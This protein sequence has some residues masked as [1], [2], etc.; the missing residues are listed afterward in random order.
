M[1]RLTSLAILI[2]FIILYKNNCPAAIFQPVKAAQ[3]MVVTADPYATQVGIEVLKKGGNAVDAAVAVAFTLAVTYPSAGNIGGGGFMMIRDS[4]HRIFALDFRERAPLAATRDMFL[5]QNG[6]VIEKLSILG[7]LAAGTPGTVHGLWQA[8][9][10]FGRLK[11][12]ALLKAAIDLAENGFIIDDYNAAALQDACADFN[13][14]L[15]AKKIFTKNGQ[16]FIAG[17]RLRQKDLAATLKRIATKGLDGFYDGLTADLI[18]KE[19]RANSGLLTKKDLQSYRS[20]WREPIAIDYRGSRIFSMP[21]PSSGGIVL[22]EI[23]NCLESFDLKTIGH[24]SANAIHLWVEIE[25]QA[26][27]DR[28]QWLGDSDFISVPVARLISR[29]YAKSLLP[30]L[31]CFV[32]GNSEAISSKN[33]AAHEAEQTTHFSIVDA[34]NN[35]VAVTYTL[36]GGYG[37]RAVIEGTGILLNNEMDDFSIKAGHPNMYG[38]IG[39]LANAIEPGKRML[40]SMTPTILTRNDSLLMVIGSPGGSTIITTVAQVISNVIDQQMNIRQA[41]EA[42]RFHHQWLPDVVDLESGGFSLDTIHSLESKGFCLRW[43]DNIGMAEG[44]LI[45][46]KQQQITGWSDPR[47]N[48]TAAGY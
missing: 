30:T 12:P 43:R 28:A 13:R 24:N 15:P 39:S 45:E 22:A 46:R 17:D 32:A 4:N 36:N 19:M 33:A 6:Q 11:W 20:Q 35:A 48:G 38:L 27:A 16:P 9:Q 2:F 21:P 14:F 29:E 26:Y 1:Q 47:G 8:H 34:E 31:S 42:P 44:I 37:S 5:D 41:I 40:S 10:K 3:G 18:E 23:L 25:R 7:C